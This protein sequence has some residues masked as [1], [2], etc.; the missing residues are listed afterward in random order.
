MNA[1]GA[2]EGARGQGDTWTRGMRGLKGRPDDWLGIFSLQKAG[3]FPVFPSEGFSLPL[4][5]SDGLTD[6]NVSARYRY[7]THHSMVSRGGLGP[8]RH[9]NERFSDDGRDVSRRGQGVRGL[10]GQGR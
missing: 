5:S 7:V 9:A 8:C 3:P 6:L 4:C 2:R 10:H 1:C